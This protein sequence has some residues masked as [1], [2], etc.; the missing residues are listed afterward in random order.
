MFSLVRAIALFTVVATQ[1]G[2]TQ[3]RAFTQ[4]NSSMEPTLLANESFTADMKAFKPHRGQLVIFAHDGLLIVK[5][6]LAVGADVVEGRELQIL[7]NGKTIDEPYVQ[8]VRQRP[9]EPK[10]LEAFGPVTV[11]VDSVF[12]AGDNRDY[13]LD[14]RDP[15]FGFV[16]LADIKGKPETIV[17]SDS[18]DRVGKELR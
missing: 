11:P 17:V 16:K 13:S 6:V 7:V 15:R 3:T 2:C 12:V 1:V 5:R 14:S 8:H 9:T 18:S 10:T 4:P